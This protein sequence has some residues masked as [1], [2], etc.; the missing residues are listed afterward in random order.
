[1]MINK[2]V[3]TSI[4]G[5]I[6]TKIANS[7]PSPMSM[8]MFRMAKPSASVYGNYDKVIGL[9]KFLGELALNVENKICTHSLKNISNPD[10]TVIYTP[11][12]KEKITIT[13][14]IKGSLVFADD[15]TKTLLDKT[16]KYVRFS[17]P[18]INTT[19]VASHLPF[20]GVRGADY[21]KEQYDEYISNLF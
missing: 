17:S 11:N 21:I 1:M 15:I 9:S 14:N 7:R 18:F 3:N 5:E 10:E 20:V 4:V 13:E 6:K 12:E 2:P 8:G 19:Q 16:N